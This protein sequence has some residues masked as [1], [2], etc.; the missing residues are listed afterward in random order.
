MQLFFVIASAILGLII[1][2]FL[3]VII[4]RMN[5]GRGIGGRSMC[6]SCNR[7]LA[8]YELIPVFSFLVQRGK[9]R[10]CASKISWQYPLV[11][12]IT[13]ILFA[14]IALWVHEPFAAVVWA[15]LVSLGMVIAVYDIR[16]KMI[17]IYFLIAFAVGGLF[18]GVHILGALAV[19]LPFLI[20]WS[21]SRGRW[22][23][24]G[25]VEIMAVMGLILGISRGYSALMISFWVGALVMVPLVLFF[26][27]KKRAH[28]PEIPFGPFLLIG[29]YL[30]GVVGVDVFSFMARMI[31]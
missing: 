23:G 31:Q 16:H 12:L 18:I 5:T 9:C 24:F 17:P 21:L 27:H 2:S 11:E 10:K 4:F 8:W 30:V 25:D 14:G 3:N 13:G 28:D 22:I 19:A 7:T 26:K 29:I 15:I 20:L 1:G 6:L